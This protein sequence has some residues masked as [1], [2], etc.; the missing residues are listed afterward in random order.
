MSDLPPQDTGS[1]SPAKSTAQNK[2]GV[3]EDFID[4]FYSPSSVYARRAPGG[5]FWIPCLVVTI[6]VGG[7]FIANLGVLQPIVDAEWARA[8]AAMMKNPQMTP[9]VIARVRSFGEL[10]TKVGVFIGVPIAMALVGVMLWLAGKLV[11][12]RVTA[13]TACII[14]AYAYVPKVLESILVGVQGLM[15]SPEQLTGRYKVTLSA[16]RFLDPDTSPIKL[17]IY[18]RVD[19]FVIWSTVLLAIGL[20]VAAKV[21]RSRAAVAAGLVWLVATIAAAGGVVFQRR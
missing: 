12:A 7:I 2:A 3:W 19:L 10:T 14:A 16:A 5:S 6:L 9:E 15:M 1:A 21:P 20:A 4:I 11:D 18:G 13:G 17:A 8:S